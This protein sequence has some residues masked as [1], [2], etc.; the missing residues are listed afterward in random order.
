[1]DKLVKKDVWKVG[2]KTWI[3]SFDDRL[4]CDCVDG[5][6]DDC[7]GCGALGGYG[8]GVV[9]CGDFLIGLGA[10]HQFAH[11]SA[12]SEDG[13]EVKFLVSRLYQT[14]SV[15]ETNPTYFP[16]CNA[17]YLKPVLYS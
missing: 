10:I 1:L 7:A 11:I 17:A 4:C 6:G 2:Y 13:C 15:F 12:L 3:V 8:F 14:L 5:A 9:D 16:N